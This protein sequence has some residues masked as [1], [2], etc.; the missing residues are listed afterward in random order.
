MEPALDFELEEGFHG[1]QARLEHGWRRERQLGG[2]SFRGR[3]RCNRAKEMRHVYEPQ[4][5]VEELAKVFARLE[6]LMQI[7]GLDL[8]GS[9][10]GDRQQ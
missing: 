3:P 7:E 1:P 9:S 6:P 8:L 10:N 2:A 4:Q 5:I